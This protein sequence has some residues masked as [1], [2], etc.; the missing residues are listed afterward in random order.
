MPSIKNMEG[1]VAIT[2]AWIKRRYICG[3]NVPFALFDFMAV[4]LSGTLVQDRVNF[5]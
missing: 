1:E 2:N 4:I 5:E 3:H